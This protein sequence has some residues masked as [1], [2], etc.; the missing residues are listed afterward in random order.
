MMGLLVMFLWSS[1]LL[2]L[3]SETLIFSNGVTLQ[4]EVAQSFSDRN[5]G[6]MGRASLDKD[7]G[8]LF[9]FEQPQHLSFWMKDTYIP[10]TIGYF[11]ENRVLKETHDLEAQNPMER[12]QDLR[13][14][15][16]ACLCQYAIEVNRGWFKKNNI[17]A[18]ASFKIKKNKKASAPKVED[19]PSL[20]E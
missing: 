7:S 6:L 2:S 20:N 1:S 17:K 8:M 10:L 3:S 16:G 19:P 15:P 9:V 5:K 11:D 14:Y 18:G 13:S 12:H 4:V